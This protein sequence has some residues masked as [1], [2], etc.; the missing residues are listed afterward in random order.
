VTP[1]AT[2]RACRHDWRP[3]GRGGRGEACSACGDRFP[4]ARPCGHL[5]CADARGRFLAFP[6]P[7]RVTDAQGRVLF[8]NLDE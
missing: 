5:D 3:A 7:V 6:F 2:R 8:T 1:R 4:C